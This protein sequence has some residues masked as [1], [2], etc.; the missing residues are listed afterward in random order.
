MGRGKSLGVE[1]SWLSAAGDGGVLRLALAL[2][3]CRC[4]RPRLTERGSRQEKS[5]T[6]KTA[7]ALPS[8]RG[9]AWVGNRLFRRSYLVTDTQPVIH[10]YYRC[11][12]PFVSVVVIV[13]TLQAAQLL[14]HTTLSGTTPA[15]NPS[16]TAQKSSHLAR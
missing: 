11:S 15:K 1:R 10:Y 8:D 13:L 4:S 14:R 16:Q 9:K 7:H 5:R 6:A 12:A 2:E 3:E